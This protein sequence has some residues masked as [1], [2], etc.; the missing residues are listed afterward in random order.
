MWAWRTE[1]TYREW[2][3]RLAHFVEARGL[4]IPAPHAGIGVDEGTDTSPLT[5]SLSPSDGERV[6]FRAG[7]GKAATSPGIH[8]SGCAGLESA[9]EEDLKGFLSELAVR[10]R[11]SIATQKQAFGGG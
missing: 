1:Q 2:A 11:V 5:P 8:G 9:T 3:W 4:R 10:G 6:P 7:E